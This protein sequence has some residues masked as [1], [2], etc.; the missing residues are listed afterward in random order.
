MAIFLS[1]VK[2][3]VHSLT[4]KCI[5]LLVGSII[6]KLDCL[7]F[8][9][10]AI[11]GKE[12]TAIVYYWGSQ[13]AVNPFFGANACSL[14]FFLVFWRDS[15]SC[16]FDVHVVCFI[17]WIPLWRNVSFMH[18]LS[19]YDWTWNKEMSWLK[20]EFEP[21]LCLI[22]SCRKNLDA[23]LSSLHLIL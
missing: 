2:S 16:R 7:V 15:Q 9:V 18:R 20:F 22:R 14:L 1:A 13:T 17:H 5:M 10:L 8:W 21:G 6:I 19:L 23:I 3:T 12:S 11:Y 4:S